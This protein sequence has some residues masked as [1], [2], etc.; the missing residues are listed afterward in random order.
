MKLT[1]F[2]GTAKAL[3]INIYKNGLTGCTN[4]G[5]SDRNDKLLI[6]GIYNSMTK[7][8]IPFTEAEGFV[9]I[10]FNSEEDM[11]KD[12]LCVIVLRELWNEAHNYIASVK[13]ILS[14]RWLMFGGNFGWTSDSRFRRLY[15]LPLP[16]HDRIED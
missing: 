2:K 15:E 10:D 12:N 13:D 7:E 4:N 1:E 9:D 6:V 16:I 5:V 3:P 14:G 11:N 8:F